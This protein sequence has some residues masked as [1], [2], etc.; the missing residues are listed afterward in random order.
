MYLHSL[1]LFKVKSCSKC[2][3]GVPL[4]YGP[5]LCKGD[6]TWNSGKCKAKATQKVSFQTSLPCTIGPGCHPEHPHHLQHPGDPE[7]PWHP[8]DPDPV[9]GSWSDWGRWGGCN[10]FI[11]FD[12]F[13]STFRWGGCSQ[14]CGRGGSRT[15][16]RQCFPPSTRGRPCHG[17]ALKREA[18]F[19]KPCSGEFQ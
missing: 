18:C 15:R 8:E 14:T 12:P 1:F 6:C 3:N 10:H 7:D 2:V 9:D 13:S 16:T 5:V 17:P 4:L 11:Q 19:Q